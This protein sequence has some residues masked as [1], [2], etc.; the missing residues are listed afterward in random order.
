MQHELR[1]SHGR[2]PI[3]NSGSDWPRFKFLM[4]GSQKKE[5]NRLPLQVKSRSMLHQGSMGGQ[6][7]IK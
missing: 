5:E 1:F 3:T 4:A 2:D 7:K 6:F